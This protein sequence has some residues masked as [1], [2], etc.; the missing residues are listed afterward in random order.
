MQQT[1]DWTEENVSYIVCVFQFKGK[2]R[3]KSILVGFIEMI[4]TTMLYDSLDT[5][6]WQNSYKILCVVNLKK[7]IEL[8]PRQKYL[9]FSI[10]SSSST[11]YRFVTFHRR[12]LKTDTKS[13]LFKST[14]TGNNWIDAFDE[15]NEAKPIVN[16]SFSSSNFEYLHA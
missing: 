16:I 8:K 15:I 12:T 10:S 4:I 6:R 9:Y 3:G 7:F 11:F 13:Q 2:T 14:H 1:T 5:S